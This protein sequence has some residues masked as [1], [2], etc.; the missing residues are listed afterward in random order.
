M[1]KIFS[2]LSILILLISTSLYAQQPKS[3][4]KAALFS[5]VLPG[6]GEY[7]SKN[8]T[9]AIISLAAETVLWLGYF[10]YLEEAK[11]A[12]ND[13]KKYVYAYSGCKVTNGSEEYYE[14]LQHY[15]SSDEWN[16]N[17][18]IYARWRL[19]LDEEDSDYF[20]LEKWNIVD[21]ENFLSDNQYIGNEAWDWGTRD[22]WYRYGELRREK[23]KFEILAK[24]TVG[25]MIINRVISMIK[26]VRT[27]H[28]YNKNILSRNNISFHLCFNPVR[29]KL[30]FALE[31]KF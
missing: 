13:Y 11:W 23:N 21:Y 26:A 18:R 28:N 20:G 9:S 8:K 27:T 30:T 15:F 10:G 5:A 3:K 14:H 6:A 24:F 1:R 31:K 25:G 4:L 2:L 29:Q 7:Y 17:V 12:E 16:N 19:G 22:I